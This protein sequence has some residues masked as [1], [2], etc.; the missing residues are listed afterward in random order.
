ML[1]PETIQAKKTI[2]H[3]E[4]LLSKETHYAS[5]QS[6]LAEHND[7]FFAL[8]AEAWFLLG[9]YTLLAL[10]FHLLMNDQI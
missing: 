3:R 5:R 8:I 4:T 7:A 1:F 10:F 6:R 2:S 9:L